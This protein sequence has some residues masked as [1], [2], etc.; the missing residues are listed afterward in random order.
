MTGR[1]EVPEVSQ[2]M[3]VIAGIQGPL[4]PLE[5]FLNGDSS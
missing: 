3:I 2:I 4:T 1:K 5:L